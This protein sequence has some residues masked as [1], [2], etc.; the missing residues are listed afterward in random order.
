MRLR[1]GDARR[2]NWP[3]GRTGLQNRAVPPR[4]GWK[5]R[6]LPFSANS[7]NGSAAAAGLASSAGT[8]DR[9]GVPRAQLRLGQL[10]PH[11]EG[12]PVADGRGIRDRQ[13]L[14]QAKRLYLEPL[15]PL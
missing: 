9:L 15:P 8:T 6:L 14:A 10:R 2:G 5:V 1:R 11:R 13:R 3:G 12:G 4:V 7:R